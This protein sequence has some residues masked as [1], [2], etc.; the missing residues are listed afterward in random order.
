MKS[1]SDAKGFSQMKHTASL[2]PMQ[3]PA[4]SA[5]MGQLEGFL[6]SS[7]SSLPEE[8][9]CGARG[10]GRPCEL[11]ARCLWAA[12][13]VCL[14]R[15]L[16]SQKAVWRLLSLGPLWSFSHSQLTASAI[17]KRLDEAGNWAVGRALLKITGGPLGVGGGLVEGGGQGGR[18]RRPGPFVAG[19]PGPGG[20]GPP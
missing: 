13:L 11:S 7:V 20:N 8:A 17:Y 16:R 1:F 14:L 9:S 10:P 12:F 4:C 19:L 5:T 3:P 2:T 15:G 6:R 18:S